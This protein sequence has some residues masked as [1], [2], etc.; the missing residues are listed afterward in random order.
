MVMR[1]VLSLRVA[2]DAEG[3]FAMSFNSEGMYRGWI[4]PDGEP[5]VA[6]YRD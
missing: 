4:A 3:N 6:I 2:L 1:F 5:D